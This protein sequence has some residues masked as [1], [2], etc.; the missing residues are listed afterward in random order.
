VVHGPLELQRLLFILEPD[1]GGHERPGLVLPRASRAA[2]DGAVVLP[3]PPR[4][5]VGDA[6]VRWL[7]RRRR[8]AP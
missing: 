8:R 1:D 4:Q 6:H 5:V 7:R 3:Q 2:L